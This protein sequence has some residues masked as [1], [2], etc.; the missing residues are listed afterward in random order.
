M[1]Q[2]CFMLEP[3]QVAMGPR[4]HRQTQSYADREG[5]A[6][7][8]RFCCVLFSNRVEYTLGKFDG[9]VLSPHKISPN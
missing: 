9:L 4:R 7:V 2:V 3:S 5:F 1:R 8:D 6:G